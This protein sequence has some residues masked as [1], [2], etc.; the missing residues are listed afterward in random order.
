MEDTCVKLVCG[1]DTQQMRHLLFTDE[2]T[3]ALQDRF[4][5]DVAEPGFKF[6]PPT[7]N[8]EHLLTLRSSKAPQ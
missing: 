3:E 5:P 8:L 6:R 1:E 7:L 2:K 4:G